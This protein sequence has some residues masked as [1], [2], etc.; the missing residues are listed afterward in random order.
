MQQQFA[1]LGL[2]DLPQPIFFNQAVEPDNEF[3]YGE[4]VGQLPL[5]PA[6][7]QPAALQDG[8]PLY[9]TAPQELDGHL[10]L[11]ELGLGFLGEGNCAA[12]FTAYYKHS[13]V[14]LGRH[15]DF[16]PAFG[17]TSTSWYNWTRMHLQPSG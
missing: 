10:Q 3:N 15:V 16:C 12:V 6:A 13:M 17:L 14:R 2:Y 7:P 1:V 9:P 8:Q 4:E 11:L 5:F